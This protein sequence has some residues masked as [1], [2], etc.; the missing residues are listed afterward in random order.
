MQL[1]LCSITFHFECSE[2]Y[3]LW[4][5][6]PPVRYLS[7]NQMQVTLSKSLLPCAENGRCRG[8]AVQRESAT[9]NNKR[10]GRPGHVR[11]ACLSC[12]LLCY[13]LLEG[14]F[15]VRIRTLWNSTQLLH[16]ELFGM[17]SHKK[18]TV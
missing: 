6:I 3:F 11:D 15:P 13:N 8:R 4:R 18:Q 16:L 10:T 9:W 12:K 1:R 7:S 5:T 17:V 2:A 14:A